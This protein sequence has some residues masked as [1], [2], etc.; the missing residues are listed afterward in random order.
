MDEFLAEMVLSDKE[1]QT[2]KSTEEVTEDRIKAQ[3]ARTNNEITKIPFTRL[4]KKGDVIDS[5]L[6]YLSE[7]HPLLSA[8]FEKIIKLNGLAIM[9][10]ILLL[11]RIKISLQ[12]TKKF[13][14]EKGIFV[15]FTQKKMAKCLKVTEKTAAGYFMELNNGGLIEIAPQGGQENEKRE[16]HHIHINYHAIEILMEI[17]GV[18]EKKKKKG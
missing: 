10:F 6:C 12:N 14:D 8:E 15:K 1:A 4:V 13:S 9:A 16:A 7:I 3:I 17:L 5:K 11:S 2:T 18:L